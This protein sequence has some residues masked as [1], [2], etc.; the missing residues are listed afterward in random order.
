VN[1]KIH[2]YQHPLSEE[3]LQI[4]IDF[5]DNITIE[6]TT[7]S[8][9]TLLDVDYYNEEPFDFEYLYELLVDDFSGGIT[10]MIEPYTKTPFDLE[11]S[12]KA[13][14][15]SLPHQLYTIEDIIIYAVLH[16]NKPLKHEFIEYF[17]GCVNTEVIHTVRAFIDN[18]MNSSITAKKLYMHR[19][20]LNYRIDNFIDATSI[21]VKTFKGANAI[22]MLYNYS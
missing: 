16:N 10:M 19:N 18:N 13:F 8:M 1:R 11:E 3:L 4:F 17:S 2:I 22:Y 15:P 20:T 14:L 12:I 21:N 5:Q 9:I 6:T 7:D